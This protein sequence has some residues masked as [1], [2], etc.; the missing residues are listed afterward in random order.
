MYGDDETKSLT[1]LS[2][3]RPSYFDLIFLKDEVSQTRCSRVL[4]LQVVIDK[5]EVEHPIRIVSSSVYCT[6]LGS[7]R[8]V[9]DSDC[10]T[11]SG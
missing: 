4:K 3:K 9:A 10:S 11:S 1:R 6:R 5:D 8:A 7:E 2:R